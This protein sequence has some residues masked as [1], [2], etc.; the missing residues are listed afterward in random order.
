MLTNVLCVALHPKLF[1]TVTVYFPE[2]L[3]EIFGVVPPVFHK[4]LAYPGEALMLALVSH[5]LT[6]S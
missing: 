2:D 5:T 4:Y 6:V 1:E 3:T